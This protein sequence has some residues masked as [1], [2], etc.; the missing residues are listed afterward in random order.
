MT[1]AFIT[2][3]TGQDG[4]YLAELLLGKGYEVHGL[5]RR[6]SSFNRSRIEHLRADS[7]IYGSSLF[8]HY[9]D[10]SDATTLR[11]LLNKLQPD[12]IYH[13]AG[14]SHV[15]LSFEL[16]ESTMQEV[17]ASCLTL[18]E[19]VRDLGQETRF[20]HAASSEV[21][22]AV[23]SAPQSEETPM[24]PHSPYG[25]AKA[26]A[27]NMCAVY[28]DAYGVHA[29]SGIAYNHESPRRGENFV[30]QKIAKAAA[31]AAAGHTEPLRLGNLSAERDWGYAPEYVD[32]MW[33]MLQL[34][35][36]CDLVLA[37]GKSTSVRDFAR[38][39]YLAAG[40]DIFFRGQGAEEQGLDEKT[41]AVL[42]EVDPAF[43]RPAEPVGLLGDAR[44]A[45]ELLEWR[46]TLGASDVARI[47]TEVA[48]R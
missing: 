35:K 44:R 32:A 24:R 36:P 22:G 34:G 46:S 16:P 33:R 31:R 1:K 42:I 47:M 14:Q 21:F 27:V 12:E 41:G 45:E 20:Y 17:A 23:R 5:V 10:L 28:R 18:L 30:T 7:V 4:S 37:T 48:A 19:I 38:A 3:I 39:A 9:G 15:G 8:L 40:K 25:C 29:C 13:L 43:F 26:F 2:G 6:A 11:R